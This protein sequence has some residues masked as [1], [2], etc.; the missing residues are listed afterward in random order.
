MRAGLEPGESGNQ[1]ARVGSPGGQGA[2][3]C[4]RCAVSGQLGSSS[5]ELPSQS[6]GPRRCSEFRLSAAQGTSTLQPPPWPLK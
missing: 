2:V 5:P 1:Q 4:A 3:L 6:V